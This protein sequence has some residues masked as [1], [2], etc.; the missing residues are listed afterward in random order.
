MVPHIRSHREPCSCF[1]KKVS[2]QLSSEQSKRCVERTVY[3]TVCNLNRKSFGKCQRIYRYV[4]INTVQL[5]G[6]RQRQASF[7]VSHR[8]S[9]AVT[10][11]ASSL[12]L[13]SKH[14]WNVMRIIIIKAN[15]LRAYTEQLVGHLFAEQP[16]IECHVKHLIVCLE[17][18]RIHVLGL[19]QRCSTSRLGIVELCAKILQ[20]MRNDF[21]DYARTFCQ[22]CAPFSILYY[23]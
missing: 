18:R 3:R 17:C 14:C 5:T 2:L 19:R 22:L 1:P 6:R 4:C 12:S 11:N 23:T 20:I 9:R 15:L 13:A 7:L 21:K 16:V 8:N 10:A